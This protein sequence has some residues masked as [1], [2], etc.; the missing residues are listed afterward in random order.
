MRV[1]KRRSESSK[2]YPVS[3]DHYLSPAAIRKFEDDLRR[4]ENVSRPR[5]LED[6]SRAQQMGDLSENAAYSEAKGRLAGIDRRIFE[7]REKLKHA[8]P[9][10]RGADDEGRIR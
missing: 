1:P 9:I 10:E 4:L 8:V 5:A 2:K 3:D 7:I 6:L